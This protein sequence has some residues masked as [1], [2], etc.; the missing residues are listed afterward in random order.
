MMRKDE[1]RSNTSSMALYRTIFSASSEGMAIVGPN[2]SFIEVNPAFGRLFGKEPEQIAGMSC[3]ELFCH[4]GT[5]GQRLC[6][7]THMVVKALQEQRALPYV[8]INCTI[9]DSPRSL[10][11]AITPVSGVD[12]ALC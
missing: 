10:D 12:E 3:V 2:A 11:I 4:E 9:D 1:T 6:S 5:D 8:E 7:N